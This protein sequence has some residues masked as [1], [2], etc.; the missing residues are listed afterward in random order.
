MLDKF[1][2][3]WYVRKT[4]RVGH[5]RA[6]WKV[7]K[8]KGNYALKRL[9]ERPSRLDLS[10]ARSLGEL[11]TTVQNCR[12]LLIA[13]SEGFLN[14]GASDRTLFSDKLRNLFSEF[15]VGNLCLCRACLL[16]ALLLVEQFDF[17]S[18]ETYDFRIVGANL[19][20]SCQ[21]FSLCHN[22]H[23]I[24]FYLS[25]W[26]QYTT[27]QPCCQAFFQRFFYFFTP[28]LF[29]LETKQIDSHRR[30]DSRLSFLW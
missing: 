16:V 9:S 2:G 10:L 22:N 17:V 7:N 11:A 20:N 4:A 28:I 12:S 30:S 6:A 5:A 26:F 29:L 15:S 14:L 23:L 21:H 13:Q 1:V 27:F 25:L 19:R 3:M 8:K 24:P 18:A